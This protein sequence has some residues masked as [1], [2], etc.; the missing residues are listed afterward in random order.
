[1]DPGRLTAADG[2][3]TMRS[4]VVGRNEIE[5]AR[6]RLDQTQ[7]P[8]YVSLSNLLKAEIDEGRWAAGAQL[9]TIAALSERYNVARVTI[10]QALGVLSSAG[11]VEGVQG[12]GTFVAKNVS[13]RK[14]IELDSNWHNLLATLDGNVPELLEERKSCDLPEALRN[15][16]KSLG[17]YHYMKRIHRSADEPY[18]VNEV[19][20]ANS[21]YRRAAKAFDT[22]MVIPLLSKLGRSKL[23]R[24]KQSFRIMS[25]NLF[26]AQCLDLPLNAPVGEVRRTITTRDDTIVYYGLGLYR[27]DCVV[28]NTTIDVPES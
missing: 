18:C 1:M 10:R 9:P 7:Q 12:K 6:R 21:Y 4:A 22:Q 13:R 27:G 24:M 23:R 26:I 14:V 8:L 17:D 20:L 11:L 15:E 25:A 2:L 16:G 5:E 19:Y 28:F 3:K